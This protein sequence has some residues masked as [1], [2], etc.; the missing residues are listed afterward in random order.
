MKGLVNKFGVGQ[1]LVIKDFSHT[2]TRYDK[3]FKKLD[4]YNKEVNPP[5][6]EGTVVQVFAWHLHEEYPGKFMYAVVDSKGNECLIAEEGLSEVDFKR[7]KREKRV[8]I[9]SDYTAIITDECI[10]VGCQRIEP[11]TLKEIVRSAR[12]MGL[13]D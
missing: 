11:K 4:F 12:E 6:P 3:M 10:Q 8:K 13:I 7:K 1:T 5:L 2:Y 9:S